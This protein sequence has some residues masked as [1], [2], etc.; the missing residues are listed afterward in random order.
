[1]GAHFAYGALTGA[2]LALRPQPPSPATGAAYGVLVW[3]VSYLGW[4]PA[5]HILKPATRHPFRR[6]ALLVAVHLI[7]G[8]ATALVLNELQRADEQ[9]FMRGEAKDAPGDV[10]D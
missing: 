5:S 6:N 7:W 8:A 4:I 1:M 10:E 9:L 2:L 3:A